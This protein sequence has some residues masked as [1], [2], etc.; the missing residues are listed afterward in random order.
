M[1]FNKKWLVKDLAKNGK[2][3]YLLVLAQLEEIHIL[4]KVIGELGFQSKFALF[5][6][7]L[8][9]LQQL[10]E[11]IQHSFWNVR[12]FVLWYEFEFTRLAGY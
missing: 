11:V 5:E 9:S 2:H 8:L 4:V 6:E 3:K 7:G 1:I 10:R 12:V